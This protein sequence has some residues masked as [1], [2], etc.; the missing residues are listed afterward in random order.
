[1]QDREEMW[2]QLEDFPDYAVSSHGRIKSLRFDRI[3][4]PRTNSYGHQRI[5]IYRDGERHDIY[6]HHLVAMTFTTG[7]FPGVQVRHSDQD[8]GNNDVYNLRFPSGKRMGQL[9]KNPKYPGVRRI[10][11]VNTNHTFRT[12][13]DCARYIGGHAT[14]VYAVLRGNRLTHMGYRFEYVEE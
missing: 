11:I 10:R 4:S 14:S 9:V 5:A 12:V 2:A 13:A 8:P 1:M 6:I 3:L 7:W